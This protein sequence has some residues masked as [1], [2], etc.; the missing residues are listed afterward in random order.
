MVWR[1]NILKMDTE[2]SDP[3]R[4]ELPIGASKICVNDFL[5]KSISLEWTGTINCIYTGEEIKKT[6]GQ[7]Y[8][9]QAFSTLARC[10]MCIVKPELC[11]YSKGT[12]REPE[13]GEKHCLQPHVLYLADTGELK[14]GIT[15]KKNIPYRWIDQGASRALPILEVSQRYHAGLLEVEIKRTLSDKTNWRK[16]LLGESCD[17]DFF[18]ERERIYDELGSYL[19]ELNAVDIEADIVHI[20]YPISEHPKKIKSL[21]FDKQKN[22]SGVLMG[23]KGQYLILDSGV[24]NLRKFQGYEI[25]FSSPD[26]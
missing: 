2:L 18:Q 26:L 3:V 13:W 7:G 9:Y 25:I 10:D 14:I 6:Y 22:I 23:I 5:G 1:G 20:Q 21:S 24:I 8:S 19:D 11:H 16:M 4:Y 15:R 17:L 12:C